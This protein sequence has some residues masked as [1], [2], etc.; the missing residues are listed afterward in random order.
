M[1]KKIKLKTSSHG[2]VPKSDYSFVLD[3]QRSWL[4]APFSELINL[5]AL[6]YVE[7]RTKS[8]FKDLTLGTAFAAVYSSMPLLDLPYIPDH[9]FMNPCGSPKTF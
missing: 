3:L 7:T 9:I 5:K 1:D 8:R 4:D 6:R 2:I